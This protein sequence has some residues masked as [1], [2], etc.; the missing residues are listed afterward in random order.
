LRWS[1][2]DDNNNDIDI[3]IKDSL[4]VPSAPMGLLCP[5][6]IAQQTGRSGDGFTAFASH[7]LLT[8]EG[9]TKSIRYDSKSRLP[10]MSTIDG[11]SAFPALT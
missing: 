2:R 9:F 11:I 3:Y 6:Q 1:I 7:G 5:Q 10:I 4:Y 8:F